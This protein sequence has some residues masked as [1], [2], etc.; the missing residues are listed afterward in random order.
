[1][2]TQPSSNTILHPDESN[3][4]NEEDIRQDGRIS[5]EAELLD[6]HYRFNHAPFAKLQEMAKP[7]SNS[8]VPSQ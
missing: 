2:K 1:M 8:G 7:Q 3:I 6:Y 5:N 4:I